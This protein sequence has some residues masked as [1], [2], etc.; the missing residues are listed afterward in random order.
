MTSRQPL[1]REPGDLRF[2]RH[3]L[4]AV[5]SSRPAGTSTGD[6]CELIVVRKGSGTLLLP[7]RGYEIVAGDVFLMQ[8]HTLHGYSDQGGLELCGFQFDADVFLDINSDLLQLPGYSVLFHF[9]VEFRKSHRFRSKLHLDANQLA[10]A[11]DHIADMEREYDACQPGYQA[12]VAWRFGL[13]VGFLAR[14]YTEPFSPWMSEAMSL[15]R[16][17]AYIQQN[18]RS[19]IT[20]NELADVACMSKNSLLRAFNRC[21]QDTP[22]AYLIDLRLRK[23]CALLKVREHSIT[24]IA[25]AVGFGDSN[26]F[27]RLFH[28]V[29]ALTPSE[30]R[31]KLEAHPELSVA[32]RPP[33]ARGGQP[34]EE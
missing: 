33:I 24:D 5:F 23:A 2:P 30:F 3:V 1:A 21:Y 22:I 29:Y 20:L 16:V 12:M 19:P 10:Q 27:S 26:Y 4:Y 11:C 6:F 17:T 32:L 8:D 13:L 31:A 9:E 18:Y 34:D 15:A 25:F 14:Q 7:D 28:S